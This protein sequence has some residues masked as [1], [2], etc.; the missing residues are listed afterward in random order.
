MVRSYLNA[1][2]SRELHPKRRRASQSNP[3]VAVSQRRDGYLDAV[4]SSSKNS[5]L[6][7]RLVAACAYRR[8]DNR[9]QN[10]LQYNGES[11]FLIRF[12]TDPK[13]VG[14]Y[15]PCGVA[16]RRLSEVSAS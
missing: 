3:S 6:Q 1:V 10:R 5:H 7:I 13:S 15:T 4:G 2:A 12:Q 16:G 8:T 14:A 11:A 9:L